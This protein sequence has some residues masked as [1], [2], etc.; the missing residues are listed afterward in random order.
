VLPQDDFFLPGP[1]PMA[2]LSDDNR[3]R[4]SKRQRRSQ[5][6]LGFAFGAAPALL[7][8]FEM[9]FD[10]LLDS[11]FRQQNHQGAMM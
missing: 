9:T 8:P 6:P 1:V 10:N 4:S 7:E 5:S 3:R 11:V 2:A